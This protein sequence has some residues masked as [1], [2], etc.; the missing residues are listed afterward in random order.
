MTEKITEGGCRKQIYQIID[1]IIGKE[2][3]AEEHAILRSILKS[4]VNIKTED[5]QKRLNIMGNTL[6]EAKFKIAKYEREKK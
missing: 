3:P 2:L 1:N 6:S 4:Y 5:L